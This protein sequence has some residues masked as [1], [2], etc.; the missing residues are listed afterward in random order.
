MNQLMSLLIG[1][2]SFLILLGAFFQLQHYPHGNLI[3]WI[4][5]M[6]SLILSSIEIDRLKRIIKIMEQENLKK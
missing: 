2:S 3:L 6:A 5:I 1:I 4:G